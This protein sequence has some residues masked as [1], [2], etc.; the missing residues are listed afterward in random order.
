[1]FLKKSLFLILIWGLLP[2]ALSAQSWKKAV[3]QMELS[4][5][6]F[7]YY[8]FV[9][10]TDNPLPKT[11]DQVRIQYTISTYGKKSQVL[12]SSYEQ[13][14]PV[15]VQLPAE[16]YDN[17]F[18][19]AVR[20]MSE[21]DSLKVMIPADSI[22]NSLGEI[23][24]F[25]KSKDIVVFTFKTLNI[26]S[27]EDFEKF[28]TEEELRADSIRNFMQEQVKLYAKNQDSFAITAEGLKYKV[29][30]EGDLKKPTK[31]AKS[32]QV[33]YLCYDLEGNLLDD[34]YKTSLPIYLSNNTVNQYI[35][36][37]EQGIRLCA[38]NTKAMLVIP[39]HLAYGSVG[40]PGQIKPN[41]TLIFWVE[42]LN[43]SL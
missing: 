4:K 10:K 3:K 22:R 26:L 37:I 5:S 31:D 36:G 23:T 14:E 13:A 39:P 40:V 21:N 42:I 34:S 8:Q 29:F 24:K 20:M 12:L 11:G 32:V 30:S 16:R 15:F 33:H 2:M 27:A 25:F 6:P 7:F 17:Y 38:Q 43:V 18:T 19:A 35:K 28:R 9:E 1:M 41:A